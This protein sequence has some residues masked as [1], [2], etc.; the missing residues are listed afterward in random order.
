MNK[1]LVN[2]N[3]AQIQKVTDIVVEFLV[4]YSFQIVGAILL[5]IIGAWIAGKIGNK[6][7]RIMRGRDI[8]ITLSRFTG[9]IVKVMVLVLVTMIALGNLGISVTPLLAALGA[10]GLGVGLAIQGMLSNY[11]AGFTI[12][13]TRPF[14]VGDTIKV[15]GVAGLVDEVHLGYT[16]LINEDN[17]RIQIPN[18]LVIGEILHNSNNNS[19]IE[20]SIGVAYHSNTQQVI[21]LIQSALSQLDDIEPTHTPIVGIDNFGDS[22]IN[23][24]VRFWA[25]TTKH[26]ELRYAANKLIHD[27]IVSAGIEI[28]F[29]QHEVTMLGGK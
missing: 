5:F 27:A 22:S 6:V 20:L 12:I 23:F 3:L 11:A 26:F 1:N 10:L 9:S 16:I 2:D 8:D 25:P 4:A 24:G 7:E 21:E 18:R 19:L 17:V 13:I 28:P 14:V 29:P 15:Q